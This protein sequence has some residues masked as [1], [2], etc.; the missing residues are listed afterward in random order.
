MK[1]TLQLLFITALLMAVIPSCKSHK[2]SAK[3]K[4]KTEQ[5]SPRHATSETS[6]D[7]AIQAKYAAM[8]NVNEKDITN[9]NLYRFVDQ[10]EGTP[11]KYGGT[12]PNGVDCS[13]FVCAL[14]SDVYHKPIPRTTSEI[15]GS[16]KNISRSGLKEGD[17]VIFDI[18]GK[19]NAHVGVYLLNG[20]FVHASSSKGVIVSELSNPYYNKAFNRGGRF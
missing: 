13:G 11:Y 18:N 6:Q 7:K 4:A 20:H 14:Y 19:K 3:R 1:R 17:I 16:T 8:M 15:E 2:R 10:W 9:L 5:T 12:T